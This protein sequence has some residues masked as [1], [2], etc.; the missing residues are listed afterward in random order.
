MGQ[1][2][3]VRDR[4][5]NPTLAMKFIREEEGSDPTQKTP[6]ASRQRLD[7]FLEEAPVTAQLDHPGIVDW[8]PRRELDSKGV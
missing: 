1:I 2:L 7:R 3:R 5:L 4:D 6:T 8:V